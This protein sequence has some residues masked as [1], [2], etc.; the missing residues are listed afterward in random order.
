MW[1]ISARAREEGRDSRRLADSLEFGYVLHSHRANGDLVA[2]GLDIALEDSVRLSRAQFVEGV[3]VATGGPAPR[4]FA[5]L[6]VH[7]F[8][9]SL[10]ECWQ[11]ASE[12]HVRSQSRA[13]WIT[14]CWPSNGSG[15]APPTRDALFTGA[16]VN[17]SAAAVASQP[18]FVRA[19]ELVLEA[20]PSSRLMFVAHSLGSQLLGDALG[21]PTALQAHLTAHP[22]R[23]IIFAAPDVEVTRFADV[24]VPAL[25]RLAERT[26]VY[27]SGRDRML[28]LSKARSGTVRAG[29]NQRAP[30]LRPG[31]ET[32]DATAGLVAEPGLQRWFGTHHALR[33][34][35]SVI[36]DIT[37]VVGARRAA[38][39]RG[40]L[41]TATMQ[42]DGVWQ[43]TKMKPDSAMVARRCPLPHR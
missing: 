18:A 43:L 33:R 3:R 25:Q 2:G 13:P 41:G 30:L 23:A 27:M 26:V 17:D 14:F 9:T 40:L 31:L 6:Y 35:S 36:F 28:A 39:C 5:A 12:T 29:A 34:A 11:Y 4:D 8:G 32:I 24:F 19:T 20:I 1:Y 7:G 38:A 15:V 22:A 37:H 16:Y 10:R 42:A 21:V